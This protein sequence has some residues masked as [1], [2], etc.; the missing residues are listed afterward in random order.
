MLGAA[1]EPAD[2]PGKKIQVFESII[3]IV[4]VL[5]ALVFNMQKAVWGRAA[6]LIGKPSTY[7]VSLGLYDLSVPM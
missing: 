5:L 2:L 4:L 1:V 6:D 3:I 7:A